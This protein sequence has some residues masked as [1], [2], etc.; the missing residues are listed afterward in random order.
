[1]AMTDLSV[2]L[3]RRRGGGR[4]GSEP[5]C[6]LPHGAWEPTRTVEFIVPAGT[7]GGA[8][9]M[10][11]MIQ[12]IIAKHGLMKQTMVVDQQGGRRRRRGLPRHQERQGQPAQA[13]HHAVEPVHHAARH[14]H[15]LLVEGHDAGVDDGARRVRALGQ[16]RVALQDRRRSI[17]AAIKAAPAGKF[18]MGGTGSKQEDQI[19]TVAH[20]EGDRQEDDLRPLQGRRRG[21]GPARRQAHRFDGQQPDRGGGAVARRRAAAAVRVRQQAAAGQGQ[22]RR[23]Q[24]VGR[25]PDLQVAR[26]STSSI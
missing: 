4:Y 9:Q 19:I 7:G 23:R 21:R 14:R 12:G 2:A 11:R 5:F 3:A 20:R 8:D 10:A 15:P 1:M 24:V 17:V 22:D 18:K 26:A 16:C 13:R 6:R 25:H